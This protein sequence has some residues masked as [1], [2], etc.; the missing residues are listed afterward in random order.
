MTTLAV[1]SAWCFHDS[2]WNFPYLTFRQNQIKTRDRINLPKFSLAFYLTSASS[3]DRTKNG[4]SHHLSRGYSTRATNG[5]LVQIAASCP[6]PNDSLVNNV[7]LVGVQPSLVT[8]LPWLIYRRTSSRKHCHGLRYLNDPQNT[9]LSQRPS[10]PQCWGF[11]ITRTH[12]HTHD[13]ARAVGLS[14]G[15]PRRRARLM[16]VATTYITNIRDAHPCHERDSNR[17]S[18]QWWQHTA[19]P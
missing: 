15:L 12:A 11:Y 14:E 7:T 6:S 18:Q 9:E 4:P 19:T 3:W 2:L 5:A 16:A 10:P 1:S 13:L 17:R 8:D